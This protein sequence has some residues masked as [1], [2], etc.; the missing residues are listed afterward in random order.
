MTEIS[1]RHPSKQYFPR[2]VTDEGISIEVKLLQDL[3]HSFPI[4][5]TL[6]GIVIEVK[7]LQQ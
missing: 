1:P 7:L 3:K 5:V 2:D 6:E 4:E